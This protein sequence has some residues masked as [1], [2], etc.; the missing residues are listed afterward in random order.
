MAFSYYQSLGI[1]VLKSLQI[2]N[3]NLPGKWLQNCFWNIC[4]VF[5][6]ITNI[7]K[8]HVKNIHIVFSIG[9][10]ASEKIYLRAHY[11]CLTSCS[12][13]YRV[14]FFFFFV[15]FFFFFFF[16]FQNTLLVLDITFCCTRLVK[17]VDERCQI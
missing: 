16:H 13:Y 12:E 6:M 7:R 9:N 4:N 17:L 15:F 5:M 1:F 2:T 3:E 10:L 8:K 14:F 11:L